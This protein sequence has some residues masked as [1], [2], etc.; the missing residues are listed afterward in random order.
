MFT[1]FSLILSSNYD[2]FSEEAQQVNDVDFNQQGDPQFDHCLDINISHDYY[3][4]GYSKNVYTIF[5]GGSS[6]LGNLLAYMSYLLSQ[7]A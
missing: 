2:K 1:G 6:D 3:L 7:I 4:L 5:G